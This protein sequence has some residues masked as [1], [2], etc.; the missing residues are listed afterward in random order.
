MRILLFT[1]TLVSALEGSND[2]IGAE[3]SSTVKVDVVGP[4]GFCEVSSMVASTPT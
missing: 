2:G 4:I 3:I 1:A